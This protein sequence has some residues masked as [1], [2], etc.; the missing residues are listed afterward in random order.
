MSMVEVL[1]DRMQ[2]RRQNFSRSANKQGKAVIEIWR[3]IT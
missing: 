2:S 1:V 3:L